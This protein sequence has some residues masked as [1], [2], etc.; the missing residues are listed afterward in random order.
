[1]KRWSIK[2]GIFIGMLVMPIIAKEPYSNSKTFLFEQPLTQNALI[3]ANTLGHGGLWAFAAYQKSTDNYKNSYYFL[4]FC[5]DKLLVQG[6]D[7]AA[8]TQSPASQR[9]VRA[10]WL[11]LPSNYNGTFEICPQSQ[12]TG[13]FLRGALPIE[14]YIDLSFLHG[15]TMGIN[16]PFLS[17]KQ[18][19]NP[20]Y[21]T[22]SSEPVSNYF[23]VPDLP[24]GKI[25][26]QHFT[27]SGLSQIE[28]FLDSLLLE[29]D[30]FKLT[31]LNS[32]IAP[33][34]DTPRFSYL[35][36]PTN[37]TYGH[38]C[39]TNNLGLTIPL[40]DLDT[41]QQV[42]FKAV[43]TNYFLFN[44]NEHRLVDL[45][46]KPWSRYMLV[47]NQDFP[48]YVIPA[49]QVLYV[50]VR[51]HPYSSFDATGSLS[52]FYKDFC[53]D[54]GYR[55]W[56]HGSERITLLRSCCASETLPF[57]SYAITGTGGQSASNSTINNQAANDTTFTTIHEDD[58]DLHSCALKGDFVNGFHA[59]CTWNSDQHGIV[60]SGG[61]SYQ[62]PRTNIMM[63][64]WSYWFEFGINYGQ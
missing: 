20:S 27:Q 54:V 16:A 10:E 34:H 42:A 35:F 11:G 55:I 21:H 57:E 15:W 1:M 44:K 56:G 24:N 6:D 23:D 59:L 38:W 52:F 39:M 47:C 43:F 40:T 22:F 12:Q 48:N 37:G 32:I 31:S 29:K 41:P 13:I 9:D 50:P 51:V 62:F 28:L 45:R 8:L 17:T 33:L 30:H 60:L 19:L 53:C 36:F 61:I 63:P 3:S 25:S 58:L 4:P 7:I 5:T 64:H 18:A 46:F 14:N 49:A 2:T 26:Q